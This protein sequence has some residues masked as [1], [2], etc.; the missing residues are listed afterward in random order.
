MGKTMAYAATAILLGVVA[1]LPVMVFTPQRADHSWYVLHGESNLLCDAE[2]S[3]LPEEFGL[4]KAPLS[5]PN[6]GLILAI[7]FICAFGVS[8]YF[9]RG[10]RCDDK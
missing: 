9:S 10:E 7:S 5:P 8:F 1:M 3:Q 2:R 6:L 4:A